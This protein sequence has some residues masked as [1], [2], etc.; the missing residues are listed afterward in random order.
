VWYTATFPIWNYEAAQ[1]TNVWLYSPFEYRKTEMMF[2]TDNGHVTSRQSTS[3]LSIAVTQ[4]GHSN[5]T[6]LANKYNLPSSYGW[7]SHACISGEWTVVETP[8]GSV[9]WLIEIYWSP[10]RVVNPRMDLS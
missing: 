1:D 2:Q 6:P 4:R 3:L 10:R 8:H 5:L 9:L 7:I